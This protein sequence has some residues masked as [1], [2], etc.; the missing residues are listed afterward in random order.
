MTLTAR[1]VR[2]FAVT[3]AGLAAALALSTQPAF[4]TTESVHGQV[5][6]E[7]TYYTNPHTVT[8]A[9]SNIYLQAIDP[10][11]GI[12]AFWYKCGDRSV[13][14]QPVDLGSGA[15][16]RLGTDF[17]AGTKFCLAAVG[18]ISSSTVS[19]DWSGR[20]DWNVLS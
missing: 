2:A 1:R 6:R 9:G 16:K 10:P 5:T 14:G 19:L 7:Y 11:V 13:K 20:L 18:D 17:R 8:T 4:A 12:R 3:G 15:R